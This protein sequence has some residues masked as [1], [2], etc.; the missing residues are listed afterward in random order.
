MLE[1]IGTWVRIRYEGLEGYV[2]AKYVTLNG[3]SIR[4][5]PLPDDDTEIPPSD[6]RIATVATDHDLLNLRRSPNSS[7]KVLTRIPK[8]TKILV[9]SIVGDWVYT[10]YQGHEGFVQLRYLILEGTG[11]AWTDPHTTG[12]NLRADPDLKAEVLKVLPAGKEIIVTRSFG[13]WCA[14]TADGVG[15]Y[16]AANYVTWENPQRKE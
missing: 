11:R 14:V 16:V 2:Q 7:A 6:D 12:V 13:D 8:G 4:P 9:R 3:E 1:F 5:E 15:G 10:S